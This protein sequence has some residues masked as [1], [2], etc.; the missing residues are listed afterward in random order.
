MAQRFPSEISFASLLVYS[1]SGSG[2]RSR[3][4]R[5]RVR[6][7]LKRGD[8]ITLERIAQR[9]EEHLDAFPGLFGPGIGLVPMPRSS[10]IRQ[11]DLWPSLLV[12]R[13]LVSRGL[14]GSIHDCLSRTREVTK[15]AVTPG[16]RRVSPHLDSLQIQR[17]I[18]LP[19]R[20]LVVDDVVTSGSTL[21][22]AASLFGDPELVHV[23]AVLRSMGSIEVTSILEPCVGTIRYLEAEDR[24]ERR[25]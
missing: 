15:A 9:V 24:T 5:A 13:A 17:S 19:A 2:E 4:S 1:V 25:P 21:Y 23:F 22:A 3:I 16:P 18:G 14:A 7:A 20:L 11:N 8:R 10:P 6:D 12:C